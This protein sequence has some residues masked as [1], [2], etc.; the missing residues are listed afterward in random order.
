VGCDAAGQGESRRCLGTGGAACGGMATE[1]ASERRSIREE[2][3]KRRMEKSQ[4]E[5]IRFGLKG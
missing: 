1:R 3:A 5:L 2:K 4:E